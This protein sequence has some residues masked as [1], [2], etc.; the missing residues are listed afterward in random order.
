LR[1]IFSAQPISYNV[2]KKGWFNDESE[3]VLDMWRCEIR[4]FYMPWLVIR[5]A[6]PNRQGVYNF[7][8]T[9]SHIT[10]RLRK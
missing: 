7:T 5:P 4:A 6:G 2:T 3:N 10:S 1:N 8:F 9:L